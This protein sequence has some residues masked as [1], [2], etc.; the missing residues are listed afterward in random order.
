M[1]IILYS[2]IIIFIQHVIIDQFPDRF[3][4]QIRIDRACA[5]S[6][7][8][9]E[10]MDFSGLSG[11][12][13]N[14]EG[15]ALLCFYKV[16]VHC[17]H[18]QQRRD[19]HMI[20][21]NPSVGKNKNIR[22]FPE[23]FVDLYKKP[24]DSSFQFGALII[25]SGNHR[26]LEAVLL[27]VLDFQHIRIGQN[28][29]NNFQDLTVFRLLNKKVSVL[30]RIDAGRGNDFFTDGINRRIRYLCE[31][32]LKIIKQRAMLMRKHCQRSVDTHGSDAFASI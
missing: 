13:D 1:I 8:R 6:Q 27:H 17:R 32:L 11:F 3:Q 30:S 23:G 26:H 2:R 14:G 28:R 12:Q 7:K 22:S 25:Q 4:R 5:V 19:R 20:L 9:C 18:G 31:K 10:V 15:S 29:M 16:L 24:V 21:V